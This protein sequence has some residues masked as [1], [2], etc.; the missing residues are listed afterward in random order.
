MASDVAGLPVEIVLS[1]GIYEVPT[2]MVN[3]NAVVSGLWIVA[4]PPG[5][6]VLRPAAGGELLRTTPGAPSLRLRGLHLMKFI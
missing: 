3:A 5:G 4:E 6:A 1:P 2:L